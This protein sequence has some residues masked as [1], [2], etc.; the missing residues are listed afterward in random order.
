M[1]SGVSGPDIITYIGV[2]LAVLGVLPIIYNTI[3]T[4]ATLA[5]VRRMLRHG[6]LA[7]VARGDVIN[8]VIEIELPRY[9][10]APLHRQEQCKE[11]WALSDYPSQLPGGTWT[12]FNWKRHHT[13][14]KTQR[15]DYSDQLRQPQAEI[16]FEGLLSFLLDLGA[17]PDPAGF[18]MLRGSGLWVPAG[19]ALLLSPDRHETVLAIGALDDSDGKLSLSVRWSSKWHMR[20]PSSLPP[21]WA[22]IRGLTPGR[23][24]TSQGKKNEVAEASE[25]AITEAIPDDGDADTVLEKSL[26]SSTNRK[27]SMRQYIPVT[28]DCPPAIRCQVGVHGLITAIPDEFDPELFD[29]LDVSH[30]EIDEMGTN[31][32]GIWFASA[33]TALSTSSATILWNYKIP[34]ELLSFAKK[35]T[36]PCG[37]LV[38]MNI[39]DE[40]ATPEWATQYDDAA[41]E[42]EAQNRK[43]KEQSRAFMSEM[44]MT[45]AEKNRAFHEKARKSH[46]DWMDTLNMKA[47]RDV[48]RAENK[49]IEA[50]Q[51]PK[52]DNKLVAEHNLLWL[53]KEGHVDESHDLKRAVDILLWRMIN[54]PTFASDLAQILDTW[55]V[56]VD[57]GGL[58]KADFLELK[59]KQPL[60][61]RASLL[62]AVIK[63]SV[64]ASQGS[65]G[66][67]LQEC[68]R[69]WRTVR[70]G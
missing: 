53:K 28:E 37:I 60:F 31:S 15:I 50:I 9:T 13:G 69:V 12:T 66:M 70:L 27:S 10:I 19:T 63:V 40:S 2:P 48:Q 22:L 1:G 30:L 52:W 59:S 24:P 41:E 67:D 68:M 56:F 23:P 35:D 11:Y 64:T 51:S 65:L 18:R 3:T 44:H 38:L 33:L 25:Q 32:T 4:L 17:V 42:Q 26:S 34:P 5:K 55:K 62:L 47:K 49:V 16:E 54:E 58:R 29:P 20:D 7:G 14:I 8:H 6:R 43:F 39:I 61:A 36:I 57:N 45:P 21:Y 46:D